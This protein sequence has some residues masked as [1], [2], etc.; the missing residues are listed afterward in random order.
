MY[1]KCYYKATFGQSFHYL[2]YM[3]KDIECE[4]TYPL[5]V[6]MH[7]AGERGSTDGSEVDLVARHGYFSQIKDGRDFHVIMVAPQCPK[8]EFWGSF[9]E[10]LNR[11]LDYIIES[12]PVDIDR[13]YLVGMSMG[14][15]ATWLWAQ[16]GAKNRIAAIAPICGEG[17][18]WYGPRLAATPVRAFHG[19]ID[20]VVSPHESLAMVSKINAYSGTAN[21]S[22]TLLAGVGHNAWDYVCNDELIDWLLSHR[23]SDKKDIQPPIWA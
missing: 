7:G 13:I 4:K 9:I 12:N 20:D 18:T 11:F 14:G 23:N 1:E 5:I 10:S 3:P 22:L 2:K 17:I 19:D 16:D 8:G 21:A 6:F 15:T